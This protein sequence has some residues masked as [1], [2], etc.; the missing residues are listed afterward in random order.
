MKNTTKKLLTALA[1]IAA[2]SSGARAQEKPAQKAETIKVVY[3]VFSLPL[4]E[5]AAILRSGI[6]DQKIYTKMVEG[7]RAQKVTQETFLVGRT[8][9]GYRS[10]ISQHSEHTYNSEAEPPILP[11]VITGGAGYQVDAEGTPTKADF[12]VIPA[13]PSAFRTSIVGQSLELEAQ[14][15][16]DRS[17]IHL[18]F[19]SDDARFIQRDAYGQGASTVEFPRFG[20]QHIK[21]GLPFKIGEPS[22]LGTMSPP[23][24]LQLENSEERTW[25]AFITTSLVSQ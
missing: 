13:L 22:Y 17:V 18:T 10:T 8:L 15:S 23:E 24:E 1:S 12:P 6:E 21:T 3:E 19:T 25:F 7:V 2:L 20:K 5:A 11:N 14:W 9:P 16:T 4:T